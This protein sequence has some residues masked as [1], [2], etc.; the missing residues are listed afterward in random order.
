MIKEETKITDIALIIEYCVL[1]IEY[2]ELRIE[3]NIQQLT[4]KAERFS[5]TL[6][7]DQA[8]ANINVPASRNS[9]HLQ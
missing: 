4:L 2:C 5:D 7:R 6:V 9:F 1:N 3:E 8:G